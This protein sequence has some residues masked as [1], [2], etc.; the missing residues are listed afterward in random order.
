MEY[1]NGRGKQTNYYDFAEPSRYMR[2]DAREL[3]RERR[4]R[5]WMLIGV[6]VAAT[7]TAAAAI[8][9]YFSTAD[10]APLD[11]WKAL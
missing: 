10:I 11:T 2:I 4:R 9:Y 5:L 6:I 1:D 3:R 7:A 8:A